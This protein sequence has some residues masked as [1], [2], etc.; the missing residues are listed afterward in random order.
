MARRLLLYPHVDGRQARWWL[1]EGGRVCRDGVDEA[2]LLGRRWGKRLA[3]WL[4]LPPPEAVVHGLEGVQGQYRQIRKAAPWALEDRLLQP[5]ETLA[6]QP[7]RQ[8]ASSGHW[9]VAV[10]VRQALEHWQGWLEQAGF[11]RV[12][13]LP[14][15]AVLPG[16]EARPVLWF[17]RDCL[18]LQHSGR[19]DVVPA[20]QWRVLLAATQSENVEAYRLWLD[21]G[22]TLPGDWDPDDALWQGRKLEHEGGSPLVV[23]AGL[24]ESRPAWSWLHP[25]L[26]RLPSLR[27]TVL[28]LLLLLASWMGRDYRQLLQ[29][30]QQAD[31]L[32]QRMEQVLRERFPDIRRVVD[33]RAQMKQR[34]DALRLAAGEQVDGSLLGLLRQIGPE[35][36]RP[37]LKL[38]SLRYRRG[39]LELDVQADGLA[40]LDGLRQAMERSTGRPV[41]MTVSTEAGSGATA[42]FRIAAGED[43]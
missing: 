27:W 16:T 29:W 8:P 6:V 39:E 25:S 41:R 10:T 30:R 20:D 14:A 19:A 34:L 40:P 7:A 33:P 38:N 15:L 43:S 31:A 26:R 42:R 21:P 3:V 37:G 24:V 1:L 32:G 9:P 35:L 22:Q 11:F 12:R 17:T 23:E 2:R 5:V 36:A 4:L 18:V 28:L 13:L